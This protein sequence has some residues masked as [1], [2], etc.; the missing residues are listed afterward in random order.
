[1][2]IDPQTLREL[3]EAL[4]NGT[5]A[6][7]HIGIINTHSRIRLQYGKQYG[8]RIESREGDGTTVIISVPVE[9]K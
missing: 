3:E 7:V 4:E 9:E 6:G 2:G 1:M 5:N 8:I